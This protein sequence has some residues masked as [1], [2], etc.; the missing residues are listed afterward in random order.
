MKTSIAT[1]RDQLVKSKLQD[2]MSYQEYRELVREHRA[3]GTSTGSEQNE[4]LS[5]YTLLN[6][7]RMKRLDKTSSLP[8]AVGAILAKSDRP[9]TW[10]V[11]TE[12]WCGD[13]AQSMPVIN[14]FAEA[15][16]NVDLRV[17]L[18]D[19]H[20][21]LMDE[22]LYNGTR[23]IPVLIVWDR[24]EEAVTHIW[25]PRPSTA[26]KMVADYKAA[27]GKLDAEFK[28]DLQ[29]WYNKD[30]SANIISDLKQFF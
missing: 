14:K 8:E 1:K 10:L 13:A 2:A 9:Q 11:I 12:S 30:R 25:G 22:F 29:V 19:E 17:V 5:N 7:S 24:Q 26:N 27:H 28:K 3:A 15:A 18:R 23:S 16:P 21:E 20:P 4:A 6:D